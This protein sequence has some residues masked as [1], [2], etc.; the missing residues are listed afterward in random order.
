MILTN[1]E[2]DEAFD[3]PSESGHGKS[4]YD[5]ARA[6]EAAVLEK[7]GAPVAWIDKD[8]CILHE[9]ERETPVVTLTRMG[10]TPLYALPE[11]KG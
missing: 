5:I 3:Q 1:K 9:E 7:L 6:I 4:R 8:L 11:V 2:V 10:W